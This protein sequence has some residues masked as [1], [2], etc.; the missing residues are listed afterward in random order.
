MFKE[1]KNETLK[2]KEKEKK[3]ILCIAVKPLKYTN[4]RENESPKKNV[5]EFCCFWSQADVKKIVQSSHC[6]SVSSEV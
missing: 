2:R 4:T 5:R 1:I 6:F 3:L